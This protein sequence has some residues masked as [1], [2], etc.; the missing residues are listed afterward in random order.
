M[1]GISVESKVLCM[2]ISEKKEVKRLGLSEGV[3]YD[4]I[5]GVS[6]TCCCLRRCREK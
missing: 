2:W 4:V 3:S 6:H 1:R 5:K